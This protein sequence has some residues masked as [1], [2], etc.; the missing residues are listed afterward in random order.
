MPVIALL[1]SQATGRTVIKDAEELKVKE[2]NRI[3]AV[4]TELS[5]MGVALV[6]TE[7]GMIIEGQQNLHGATVKSYGD[8]RMGMMLQIA[9]LL[10]DSDVML[11][12]A[13]AVKVSYPTFFEDVASLY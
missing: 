5:K 2:T 9:A 8:H 3:D 6:G 10:A 11:E 4:V 1:A 7:D 13:E 12:N